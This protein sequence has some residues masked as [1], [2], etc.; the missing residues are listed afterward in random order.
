MGK[1]IHKTRKRWEYDGHLRFLTFSCYRNLNLFNH[2][3]RFEVF[4]DSL[5]RT[6]NVMHM[7]LVG[8]VVMPNHVHLIVLPDLTVFPIS[9][10]LYQLKWS[11]S[12]RILKIIKH[13][14][15]QVYDLLT[16]RDGHTHFWQVGGGYDRNIASKNEY[17]D[18]MNYI[19]NN[20]VKG[21]LVKHPTDWQWSSAR[22]YDNL[23]S[24]IEI[25]PVLI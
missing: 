4:V 7:E 18:K 2:H 20:P 13:Q 23:H 11:V 16:D 1:I 10:I 15:A 6:R 19:H 21:N 14:N 5:D 17:E 8:W 22:W 24:V 25:D 3:S 9:K 12:R